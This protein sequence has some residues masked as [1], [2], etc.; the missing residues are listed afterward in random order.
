MVLVERGSKSSSEALA[1]VATAKD[2]TLDVVAAHDGRIG[3]I[4]HSIG[5][6]ALDVDH[7]DRE[8]ATETLDPIPDSKD[9][10]ALI[11]YYGDDEA[12]GNQ[13]WRAGDCSGEVRGAAGLSHSA[14][15]RGA[16]SRGSV[17]NPVR[18]DR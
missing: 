7:G 12:R 2:R 14:Q 5:A 13:K 16:R 11:F 18:A 10:G 4:P 8:R 17:R 15:R 9:P 6:T 1:E 3:L